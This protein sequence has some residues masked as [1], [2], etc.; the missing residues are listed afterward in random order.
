[1]LPVE[2]MDRLSQALQAK[3]GQVT[4]VKLHAG[5]MDAYETASE[6][7]VCHIPP[8]HARTNGLCA[9]QAVPKRTCKVGSRKLVQHIRV[10]MWLLV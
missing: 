9:V 6:V 1:M 4:L 3:H 5:H 7:G 8:A 2:H 10:C